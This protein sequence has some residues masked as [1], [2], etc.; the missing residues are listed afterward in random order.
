MTALTRT[1][2]AVL[3]LSVQMLPVLAVVL[4][5]RAALLRQGS[6]RL[7]FALWAVVGFRLVC[8]VS[9]P[10]PLSLFNLRSA[11]TVQTTAQA[12]VPRL[13]TAPAQTAPPALPAPGLAAG[14]AGVQ[15]GQTAG[16]AQAAAPA[17]PLLEVLAVIWAV[18]V[19]LL[20]A[21]SLASYLRL[22]RSVAP[23]VLLEGCVYECDTV[24]SPFVLGFFRPRIYIPFRLS[25]WE[26]T[27]VLLHERAHIRRRDYLTKPL[28]FLILAVYWFHPGVWL[29]WL[30]LCRDMEMS[31]DEAVLRTLG[32]EAKAD[33][34]R[35]LLHFASARRFPAPSPLAFGEHDASAR[36]RHV[37]HWKRA[38][39]AVT[40]LAAA[41]CILAAAV[42]GTDAWQG[43]NTL[44]NQGAEQVLAYD[45]YTWTYELPPDTRE[46]A[47]W[48]EV[49]L[50]GELA[51][52]EAV[53]EA[54]F[55]SGEDGLAL[56]GRIRLGGRLDL[57]GEPRWMLVTMA[58]GEELAALQEAAWPLSETPELAEANWTAR[59]S[60]SL[61]NGAALLTLDGRGQDGSPV[62]LRLTVV[63]DAPSGEDAKFRRTGPKPY[64]GDT[65]S[66]LSYRFAGDIADASLYQEVYLRGELVSQERVMPDAFQGRD[67]FAP[68]GKLSLGLTVYRDTPCWLWKQDGQLQ[69]Q[70]A[71]LGSETLRSA[72]L[73]LME[74]KGSGLHDGAVLGCFLADTWEG[75]AD[76][77]PEFDPQEDEAQLQEAIGSC[78]AAVLLRLHLYPEAG[79]V[80]YERTDTSAGQA[81]SIYRLRSGGKGGTLDIYAEVYDHGTLYSREKIAEGQPMDGTF[82]WGAQMEEDWRQLNLLSGITD[83][84]GQV[85]GYA[86]IPVEIPDKAYQSQGFTPLPENADMPLALGRETILGAAV[87]SSY[88]GGDRGPAAPEEL[89]NS[90]EELLAEFEAD[91][92]NDVLVL[93]K[94]V[95]AAEAADVRGT[96]A[97][98]PPDPGAPYPARFG[99]LRQYAYTLPG[100]TR[101]VTLYEELYEHGK[102]TLGKVQACLPVGDGAGQL[103]QTGSVQLAGYQNATQRGCEGNAWYLVPTGEEAHLAGWENHFSTPGLSSAVFAFRK[104]EFSL[105]ADTGCLAAVGVFPDSTDSRDYENLL[106]RDGDSPLYDLPMD[107][108]S[109]AAA[110]TQDRVS[111]LYLIPSTGTEPVCPVSAY[112]Q[113][114]YESRTEYLGDAP[115]LGRLLEAM[116]IGEELGVYTMELTT[117]RRPYVLQLNFRDTPVDGG[118][119]LDRRMS[120]YGTLL[121]ALVEN[122]EEVRWSWPEEGGRILHTSHYD[123]GLL[124]ALLSS[125]AT[126]TDGS[127]GSDYNSIKDFAASPGRIQ[128]LL[129][130]LSIDQ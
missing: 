33:Y 41:L 98:E 69:F 77:M 73:G 80:R 116:G 129:D 32:S 44:K 106:T 125:G 103:A 90:L 92:V 82:A 84:T 108:R 57:G 27:C 76:A 120:G 58:E 74:L 97:A 20:L 34:S 118:L 35:S 64:G 37:L 81:L 130:Y 109:F 51:S 42:C 88:E 9:L 2:S 83:E 79:T 104:G 102:R 105:S 39:P 127:Q 49:W 8:P 121:L 30:L 78:D 31:C 126:F 56:R 6:R 60:G 36:I 66:Q 115:A 15:A 86:A 96:L 114:L 48:T 28:A 112:A 47:L 59:G 45:L 71:E 54:V 14:P 67:A 62:S 75:P 85:S 99:A 55:Q 128:N 22:R 38:A 94:A 63:Y 13:E 1:F 12:V 119:A 4:M 18:G 100:G 7:A 29:S 117:S 5:V 26:R 40:F 89:Q 123:K 122:L 87:L 17:L 68:Q 50:D 21:Y 107:G 72:A 124:T 11:R 52:R 43:V 110:C 3:R 46:A 65:L 91:A 10:S 101:S 61:E 16:A 53:P 70:P 19:A 24:G 23:A 25:A 95:P 93:I 111:L 113:A